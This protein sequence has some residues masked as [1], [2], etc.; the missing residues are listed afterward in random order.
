M[1]LYV[2]VCPAPPPLLP[3]TS[4]PGMDSWILR[5]MELNPNAT[6]VGKGAGVQRVASRDQ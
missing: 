6:S 3:P 2:F 1:L 4:R 5:V